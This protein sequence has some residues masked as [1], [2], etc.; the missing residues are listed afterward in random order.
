VSAPELWN[1]GLEP[2]P[3]VINSSVVYCTG[4]N[5]HLQLTPSAQQTQ[6][7]CP[8]QLRMDLPVLLPTPGT[9]QSLI[10]KETVGSAQPVVIV[11][12]IPA[13][14]AAAIGNV[15][16]FLNHIS[17]VYDILQAAPH[18]PN[19]LDAAVAANQKEMIDVIL[20]YILT[21]VEGPW[22]TRTWCE[23]RKAAVG[24]FNALRI[25]VRLHHHDIANMLLST[26]ARNNSPGQ[27]IPLTSHRLLHEDCVQYG[28]VE[29]YGLALYYK[30]HKA[31]PSKDCNEANGN[32]VEH[33]E[34]EVRYLLK[35]CNKWMLRRLIETKHLDPNC[36][37]QANTPI[38]LALTVRRQQLI[39]VLVAAGADIDG[40]PR[41]GSSHAMH[42]ALDCSWMADFLFL[43]GLGARMEIK[44]H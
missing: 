6:L 17:N 23:M 40:L 5:S 3:T 35:R 29:F 10:P 44:P 15:Q 19:A 13:A 34:D 21:T 1:Y 8:T 24:L 20:R 27:T 7:L 12:S 18:F 30:R 39:K 37:G 43:K 32:L 28:N 26:L 22:T 14:G 9:L 25:A 36:V 42:R 41:T 33:S 2:I 11:R 16:M 38:F 31:W 4:P